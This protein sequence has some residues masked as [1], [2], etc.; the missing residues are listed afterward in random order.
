MNTVKKHAVEG[1]TQFKL[2][3]YLLNNLSQFKISPIAKLVLL[4]L[5]AFYNPN[6][7]DVFPKQKTL[8]QKIGVSE[9]SIVRAIQELFKEGLILI[10]CKSTNRYIFTSQIVAQQPQEKIFTQENMSDVLC[11]NNAP[12]NDN[13]SP[14]EHEPTI[15]P[16]IEPLEVKE[17]TVNAE[18]YKI[19]K[20][21]A[22]SNGARNVN[23][24][25]AALKRNGSAQKILL[26][27]KQ[28]AAAER[29]WQKEQERTR[30]I[31]SQP[32]GQGVKPTTCDAI[33]EF[34]RKNGL[35]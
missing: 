28:K 25:I 19:L 26:E 6:K 34:K 4:E 24:Y 9:R 13:L 5:S 30:A 23:A 2:T 32:R 1:F 18:E 35:L 22:I 8:A 7:P 12:Q 16:T 29:F 33:L 17:K 14:H 15:K 31:T 20:E 21:Y 3:N 10:E 27:A 11:Q